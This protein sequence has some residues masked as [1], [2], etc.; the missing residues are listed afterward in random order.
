MWCLIFAI[1]PCEAGSAAQPAQEIE[2]PASPR[3]AASI[4]CMPRAIPVRA[5]AHPVDLLL[6]RRPHVQLLRLDALRVSQPELFR[7]RRFDGWN[8]SALLSDGCPAAFRT[9]A[10]NGRSGI[11]I[12][13]LGPESS[14]TYRELLQPAWPQPSWV[15]SFPGYRHH[16][17]S[18][19]WPSGD[20]HI[21]LWR[22]LDGRPGSLVAL[23]ER[24]S[25]RV[26][27]LG[28]A[29]WNYDGVYPGFEVHMVRFILVDEPEGA[30][31]LY[32]ATYA[33]S[34]P[35]ACCRSRRR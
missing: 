18:A 12:R 21:G 4:A 8:M 24:D 14:Q 22:R 26:T 31:P 25:R 3:R 10:A 5:T 17:S 33:R 20:S 23:Y 6:S 34:V 29:R 11:E 15:P 2:V 9:S 16:M 13:I 28:E 27:R 35:G 32:M 30:Q 1:L 19:M 7:F